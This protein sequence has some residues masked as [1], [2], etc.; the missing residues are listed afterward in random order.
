MPG[1]YSNDLRQRIVD[2]VQSG[3]HTIPEIAELFSVHQSF[4]YRLVQHLQEH[5][6]L[7]PLPRGGGAVPL[8]KDEQLPI[9]KELVEQYPDAT[10]VELSELIQKKTRIAVSIWTVRRGLKKL[11]ITLKK[12]PS[13]HRKQTRMSEE[14]SKKSR[15]N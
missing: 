14:N 12:K 9:L 4:I 3:E 13:A 2:A 10:L 1:P 7:D 5:G 8:L 11:R 6:T 15:K